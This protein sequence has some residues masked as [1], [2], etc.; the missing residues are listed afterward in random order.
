VP[1]RDDAAAIEALVACNV[2]M[3]GRI[4]PLAIITLASNINML[5]VIRRLRRLATTEL[6]SDRALTRTI[7]GGFQCIVEMFSHRLMDKNPIAFPAFFSIPFWQTF[8]AVIS[9]AMRAV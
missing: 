9:S 3:I 8:N 7:T 6:C 5:R 2:N 4:A 1:R